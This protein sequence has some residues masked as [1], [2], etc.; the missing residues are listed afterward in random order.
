MQKGDPKVVGR[1]RRAGEFVRLFNCIGRNQVSRLFFAENCKM[2]KNVYH[3]I[4]SSPN[5]RQIAIRRRPESLD[6]P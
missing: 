5:G 6:S 4:Y 1:K 2:I 3:D